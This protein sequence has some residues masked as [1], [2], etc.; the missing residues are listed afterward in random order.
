M[1]QSNSDGDKLSP[2]RV[3]SSKPPES[4]MFVSSEATRS[5]RVAACRQSCRQPL[6]TR[7][8]GRS[9]PHTAGIL[10]TQAGTR[11]DGRCS[12]LGSRHELG[13]RPR[14]YSSGAGPCR[15][16]QPR[17]GLPPVCGC[18]SSP[19]SALSA[20]HRGLWWRHTHAS[21]GSTGIRTR[22]RIRVQR[23]P[24][25]APMG[26]P[27]EPQKRGGTGASGGGRAGGQGMV[28]RAPQTTR[29]SGW[30]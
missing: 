13:L 24:R 23:H 11:P 3:A 10:D 27:Q 9:Q 5:P 28:T 8:L 20:A 21:G 30:G 4:L 22:T 15:G 12:T 29:V 2:T 17:A 1:E 19:P 6:M 26:R 16:P 7:P 25:Y 18:R 14:D